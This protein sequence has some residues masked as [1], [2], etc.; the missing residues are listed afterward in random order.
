MPIKQTDQVKQIIKDEHPEQKQAEIP[1]AESE[2]PKPQNV[3]EKKKVE[4]VKKPEEKKQ[5]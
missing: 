2:K 1:K 3:E 4:E 5:E